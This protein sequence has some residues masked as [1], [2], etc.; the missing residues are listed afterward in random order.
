MSFWTE[1]L[2]MV[3]G[4]C[5]TIAFLP[6]VIKTY[7]SRSARDLSLGMFS[8]FTLGVILWLAYGIV[9]QE[10]PIILANAATLVMAAT[11]LVFK[12]TWRDR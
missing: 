12:L 11:L 6:Q 10:L 4:I 9:Q 5:T 8:I 3:A 2:G 7:R 1:V